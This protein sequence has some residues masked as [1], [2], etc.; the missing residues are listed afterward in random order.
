MAEEKQFAA[1]PRRREQARAAG[2]HPRGSDLTAIA[3]VLV[4]L[5]MMLF[6]GSSWLEALGEL[7]T[8]GLPK[9]P[10]LTIQ[11]D[12]AVDT[13]RASLGS[14]GRLTLPLV[15]IVFVT[16]VLTQWAQVGWNWNPERVLPDVS[17]I[18]PVH[19][20]ASMAHFFRWSDGVLV[21]LR[22]TVGLV[23]GIGT[24]WTFRDWGAMDQSSSYLLFG[25]CAQTS[26]AIVFHAAVGLAVVSIFE[27]GYQWWQ[28]EG[29]LQMTAEEAREDAREQEGGLRVRSLQRGVHQ[30]LTRGRDQHEEVAGLE[31]EAAHAPDPDPI[32]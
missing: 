1:S 12:Q 16:A 23:I 15:A 17:R 24:L 7:W 5:A 20:F 9:D 8:I 21:L 6:T 13:L 10:A 11:A 30:Q 26:V 2:Q 18:H 27:Y 25:R 32:R 28:F 14:I 19:R 3:V 31:T 4:A 22:Y 29:R